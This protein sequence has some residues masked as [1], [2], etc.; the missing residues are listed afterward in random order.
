MSR[1][2]SFWGIQLPVVFHPLK[3]LPLYRDTNPSLL[4][5][6]LAMARGAIAEERIKRARAFMILRDCAIYLE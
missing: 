5:W 2:P 6:C 3:S 4:L 1:E